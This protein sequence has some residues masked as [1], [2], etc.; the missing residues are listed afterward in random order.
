MPTTQQSAQGGACRGQV[1][2]RKGEGTA[3]QVG[4]SGEVSL[5]KVRVKARGAQEGSLVRPRCYS[6]APRPGG[7]SSRPPPTAL[8]WPAARVFRVISLLHVSLP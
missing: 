2:G 6:K 5:S 3:P 7:P 1:G 4:G 8:R